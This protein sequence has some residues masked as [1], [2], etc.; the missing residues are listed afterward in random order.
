MDPN[1]S[2]NKSIIESTA[3]HCLD[4]SKLWKG[5]LIRVHFLDAITAFASDHFIGFYGF[6]C[7]IHFFCCIHPLA[8]VATSCT[9]FMLLLIPYSLSNENAII[10]IIIMHRTQTVEQRERKRERYEKG[11]TSTERLFDLV[12]TDV[13]VSM[14]EYARILEFYKN[15]SNNNNCYNHRSSSQMQTWLILTDTSRVLVFIWHMNW[16][17]DNFAIWY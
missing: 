16:M 3:V 5:S 13:S 10:I 11:Q 14:N 9:L 2:M 1:I 4:Y 8:S 7:S 6:A 15:S 17:R 12:D